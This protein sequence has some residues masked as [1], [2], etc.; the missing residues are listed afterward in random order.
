M[1]NVL[2]A[3]H[4]IYYRHICQGESSKNQEIIKVFLRRK[5]LP[6]K[7]L[8]RAGAAPK[9]VF[10]QPLLVPLRALADMMRRDTNPLRSRLQDK[11]QQ[12]QTVIL[13]S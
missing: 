5:P 10:C 2:T 8:R 9:R 3:S 13:S 11:Q 4:Y 12:Q 7:D 1:L 6:P